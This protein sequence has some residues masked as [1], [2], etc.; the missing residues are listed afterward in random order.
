MKVTLNVSGMSCHHCKMAVEKE[1]GKLVGVSSV[2]AFPK[3][4][5]VE[6]EFDDSKV[7]LDMIKDSIEE[8][9]YEVTD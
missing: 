4:N 7:S 8:A 9:G 5:R 3:E 6:V 2:T 1:V